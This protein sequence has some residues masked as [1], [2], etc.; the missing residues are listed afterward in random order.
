MSGKSSFG[1]ERGMYSSLGNL[2]CLLYL[3]LQVSLEMAANSLDSTL[4]TSIASH[5]GLRRDKSVR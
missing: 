4:S 1:Y 2:Q 3:T 5:V